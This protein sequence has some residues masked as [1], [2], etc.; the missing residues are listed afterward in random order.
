MAKYTIGRSEQNTVTLD[1]QTVSRGH[2]ELETKRG[3]KFMLR[4]LGSTYG[5][6]ILRDGNWIDVIEVEVTADTE[7]V[8]G[9]HQTT[10]AALVAQAKG[11]A[12]KAA[13]APAAAAPAAPAGAAAAAPATPAVAK[14]GG[15]MDKTTK[16][17]LIGGGAVLVIVIVAAVLFVVL[18][19]DDRSSSS[20]GSSSSSSSGSSSSGGSFER[21]IMAECE[22]R[23]KYNATQCRCLARTMV[24]ALSE[25]ELRILDRIGKAGKS[26]E[27]RSKVIQEIGRAKVTQ[28]GLKMIGV[29]KDVQAKCGINMRDRR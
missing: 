11:S 24:G 20:S 2:A 10:V 17:I 22:A 5:T 14:S 4:D 15:G 23:G 7:V 29:M 26:A 12:A 18:T 16:W 8:L 21:R 13:P 1:D 9:E 25:E 6:K 19:G 27:D 28:I 3:G